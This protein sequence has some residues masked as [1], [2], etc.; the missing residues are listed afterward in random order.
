MHA[1]A[2]VYSVTPL[3]LKISKTDRRGFTD[4]KVSGA[5][6]V[7]GC[8]ARTTLNNELCRIALRKT[9]SPLAMFCNSSAFSRGVE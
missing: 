7:R 5:L 2:G 4:G 1:A 3:T 9:I 8:S 6:T